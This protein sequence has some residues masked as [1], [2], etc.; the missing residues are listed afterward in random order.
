MHHEETRKSRKNLIVVIVFL[1]LNIIPERPTFV[2]FLR[3][4]NQL[5]IMTSEPKKF[6]PKRLLVCH[7]NATLI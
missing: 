3:S 6:C 7:T 5:V 2:K 1:V 4:I